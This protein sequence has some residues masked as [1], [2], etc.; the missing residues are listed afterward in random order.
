MGRAARG[1]GAG[2]L[3]G[4]ALGEEAG[5]GGVVVPR[6]VLD[7]RGVGAVVV[8]REA[9]LDAGAQGEAVQV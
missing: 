8:A 7:Q 6:D 1:A 4:E 3:G 2:A 9:E 5:A